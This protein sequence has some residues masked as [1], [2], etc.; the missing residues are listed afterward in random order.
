MFGKASWNQ[1]YYKSFPVFHIS[2]TPQSEAVSLAVSKI[3]L[4]LMI[5]ERRCHWYITQDLL[6]I[7][8]YEYLAKL[9]QGN[10]LQLGKTSTL[11]YYS[12][13][14][15]PLLEKTEWYLCHLLDEW[16]TQPDS[17]L[18]RKSL[19]STLRKDW[20]ISIPP[21]GWVIYPTRLSFTAQI[22]TFHS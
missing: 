10:D 2:Y 14:Y 12:N 3:N 9:Q 6:M 5:N 20:V 11:T 4:V 7:D 21:F 8:R 16:F 17:H 13:H 1:K 15:F 22:I 18:Q 19:L